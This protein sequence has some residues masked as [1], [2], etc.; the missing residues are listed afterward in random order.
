MRKVLWLLLSLFMIAEARENPFESAESKTIGKATQIEETRTDFSTVSAT[1]PSSARI[2]RSL[3]LTFQNLDGSISEEIVA[4][5][6]NIDWHQPLILS[7]Q[8]AAPLK[9]TKESNTT[10]ALV[11]AIKEKKEEAPKSVTLPKITTPK[12]EPDPLKFN[13]TLALSVNG[14]EISIFTQDTKVRDFLIADPY[15][16]VVDF[17]KNNTLATQTLTIAQAP[18]VSATLGG[19]D[20][21][22][23]VAILL[24]GHYRY[25]ILPFNG[26]YVI[27]L[28]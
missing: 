26:G 17:K 20:G 3:T 8:K 6:Q 14:N 23:R 9:E 27:R 7:A 4:I 18:F 13:T 1:L 10:Q 24:D 11:N 19:H 25:D 22:Y 28:K 12:K 21:F 15:K 5:D 2:L 16:V